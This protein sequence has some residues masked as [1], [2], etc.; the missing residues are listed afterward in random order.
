MHNVVVQAVPGIKF[1]APTRP[2]FRPSDD[3]PPVMYGYFS[4]VPAVSV[5]DMYYCIYIIIFC[6]VTPVH[7]NEWHVRR[8]TFSIESSSTTQEMNK[9]MQPGVLQLVKTSDG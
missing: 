7:R 1:G 4:L 6:I 2:S 9:M 5:H 8:T 3:R